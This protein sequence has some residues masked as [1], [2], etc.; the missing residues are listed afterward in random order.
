MTGI[1]WDPALE[2]G[3][4]TIDAQHRALFS[5]VNQLRDAAVEGR[6]NEAVGEVLGRLVLYVETHFAEEQRL[7]VRTGYPLDQFLPHV[8]AHTALTAQ[9]TEIVERQ[10]R[11]ELTT[12]LPVTEF[13]VEW[14]RTHIR[15]VDKRF[16]EFVRAQGDGK[17]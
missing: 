8:E 7:M 12:I 2:T 11:G 10:R 9:T 16:V 13:L 17:S 1:P 3:D 15:Q 6:A 14:L 5:L 4:A